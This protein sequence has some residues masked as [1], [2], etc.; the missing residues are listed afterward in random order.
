MTN[1]H[2]ELTALLRTLN[3]SQIAARFE[4]VAVRAVREGRLHC[5]PSLPFGWLD[6]PPGVNRLPGLPWLLSRLH[7]GASP[8]LAPSSAPRVRPPA[9]ARA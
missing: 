7:P 1:R 4:D 6:G 2:Q 3:L 8:A 5:A 9:Q